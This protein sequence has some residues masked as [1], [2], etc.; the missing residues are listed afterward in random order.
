MKS[1]VEISA[2]IRAEQTGE[3]RVVPGQRWLERIPAALLPLVM[4]WASRRIAWALR[5]GVAGV[6]NLG[7][8]DDLQGGGL[9]PGAGTV[10]VTIGGVITRTAADGAEQR[11]AHVTLAFDHDVVDGAPAARFTSRLLELLASGETA[12]PAFE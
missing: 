2:E 5:Y 6:N 1:L 9:A 10:A 12:L 11:V 7:F 4:G 3:H 8:G